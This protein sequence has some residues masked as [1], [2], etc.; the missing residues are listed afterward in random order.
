MTRSLGSRLQGSDAG[1]YAAGRRRPTC[2]G[3]PA[4]HAL[5]MGGRGTLQCNGGW[6]AAR[7]SQG[8]GTDEVADESDGFNNFGWTRQDEMRCR[9]RR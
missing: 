7:D 8:G 5:G 4:E 9:K 6:D 2:L 3:K 1:S